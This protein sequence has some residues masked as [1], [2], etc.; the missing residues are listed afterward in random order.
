MGVA[1]RLPGSGRDRG[2]DADLVTTALHFG[3]RMAVTEVPQAPIEVDHV[4]RFIA[5][6]TVQPLQSRARVL[7]IAGNSLNVGFAFDHGFL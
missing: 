6:P 5:Q 3:F 4:P 2:C 7:G 1:V